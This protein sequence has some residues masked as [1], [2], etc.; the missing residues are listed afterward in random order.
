MAS[1]MKL[2][3]AATDLFAAGSPVFALLSSF[4][5]ANRR[6]IMVIGTGEHV[7]AC[8]LVREGLLGTKD[9]IVLTFESLQ[10]RHN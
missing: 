4:I 9:D 2:Y 1:C 10:C 3:Q 8:K 6:P 7:H 5:D